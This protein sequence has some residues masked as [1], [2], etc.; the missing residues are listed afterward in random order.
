MSQPTFLP[1]G[2]IECPCM[3]T[4]VYMDFQ[5]YLENLDFQFSLDIQGYPGFFGNQ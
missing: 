1:H 5:G 4:Q 2:Y 3:A